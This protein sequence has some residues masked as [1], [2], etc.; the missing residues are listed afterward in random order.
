MRRLSLRLRGIR[1][2]A[3]DLCAANN[4]CQRLLHSLFGPNRIITSL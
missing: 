2:L 4:N 3:N 1:N